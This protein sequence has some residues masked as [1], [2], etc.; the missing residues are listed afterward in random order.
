MEVVIYNCIE[1]N[2]IDRFK[3][4]PYKM[5]TFLD[6]LYCDNQC[7]DCSNGITVE[8]YDAG[9]LTMSTK[10]KLSTYMQRLMSK[11]KGLLA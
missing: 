7:N 8:L 2:E 9:K 5:D 4:S 6:E 11:D 3:L 10:A 1:G